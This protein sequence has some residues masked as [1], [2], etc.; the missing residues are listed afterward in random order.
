ML[1]LDP[2][3][4]TLPTTVGDLNGNN[5]LKDQDLRTTTIAAPST[6]SPF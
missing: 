6:I 5:N 4:V 3:K 1:K 2:N